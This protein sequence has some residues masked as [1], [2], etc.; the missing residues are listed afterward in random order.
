MEDAKIIELFW[1]RSEEAIAATEEKYGKYCYAIAYNIIYSAPDSEEC[2]NDTYLDAWDA[3]PPARPIY[4]GAFLSKITRRISIDC[5]RRRHRE[6]RG[7][8]DELCDE[9]TEAVPSTETPFDE[10]ENGRLKDAIEEFISLQDKEKRVAFVLRYF[11]SKPIGEI[12]M[13]LGVKES[14][15]KTMLFRMREG[16]KEFLERRDLF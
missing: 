6:K 11:Y 13:R 3:M 2:V 7:G 12:A 15:V 1:E 4:L 5:Y 16:L 10:Y 8:Y 14:K 9:L